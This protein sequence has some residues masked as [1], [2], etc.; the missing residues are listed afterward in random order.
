MKSVLLGSAATLMV[1]AGAQAADLPTKKGAPAV[2]Y[3]KV[4]KV[5]GIAGFIIPGSD[6]CL[7]ISGYVQAHFS[8]GNVY[9]RAQDQIGFFARGNVA[10]DAVTNTA[11]GPLLSHIDYNG[12]HGVGFDYQGWAAG[13]NVGLDNAYIQWAGITAGQHG[14]FFDFHGGI[15]A[16]DDLITPDHTGTGTPLFAYTATFGGGFAA[17]LSFE[18]PEGSGG[19]VAVPVIGYTIQG[20]RAPDVVAAL[21]LTQGWGAVHLAGLAHYVYGTTAVG[22]VDQWGY[23]GEAGVTFNIPGLAGGT[24][25][26]QVVYTKDASAYIGLGQV[27]VNLPT[28]LNWYGTVPDVARIG[29]V[30]YDVTGWST[31]VWASLPFSPNFSVQPE[32]SYGYAS[33]AGY[34]ED[35][36]IGGATFDYSPVKNLD[37]A[38]DILYEE[39]QSN[40]ATNNSFSGYSGKLRVARSF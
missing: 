6:T 8:V 2:E 19:T 16:W 18:A 14:S 21:D 22:N 17:T 38:I 3:V 26:G 9:T 5:G 23:A 13:G 25:N 1:A 40:A 32:I 39:G 29:G 11:Y 7:K 37:F 31:A 10:F 35:A 28:G 15:G 36:W 20:E 33:F 4:C 12:N 24:L 34:H 27:G 30:I